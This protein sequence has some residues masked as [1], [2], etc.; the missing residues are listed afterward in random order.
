MSPPIRRKYRASVAFATGCRRIN[1]I[2]RG[3]RKIRVPIAMWPCKVEEKMT[4]KEVDGKTIQE[5]E[6]KIIAKDGTITRV[7]GTFQGYETSEEESVER[8][9]KRDLYEFVNHP[10]LQQRSHRNEFAPDYDEERAMEPRPEPRREATPTLRLRS[11]GVRR[12]RERVV[13]SEE[14]PNREGNRRG[15]NA[16]GIRPSDEAREGNP[17]AGDTFAYHPQGGYIPQAFTNNSI[18]S[19]NGPMHPIV[20]P[21]SNYPFYTQPMYAPPNMPVYP[22]PAG[23]FAD[24]ASF[25]TPFVRWIEDYPLPDELKMPSHIGSYDGKGDPD[26][27]LHLF[28]GVI[29]MQKWL[30]PAK[31]RS[32]FSRKKKFTKTHLAVYNI[33]QREGESTRAFI[34]RYT[35]DTLQI[36][37]SHEEQ[38]ISGFI[39]GLRTRSLVEHLSTDLPSTYKDLMEKAYTWVEAR[40]VVT[41]GVLNN[42]RDDSE[43]SKK[44]SWG[45]NIGQK[46]RGRFS[47]YKGQNHKLLFNLVKSPKEILT[48]EKVAKTFKQPLG[49]QRSQLSKMTRQILHFHEDYG[50]ETNQLSGLRREKKEEKK[51]TLD[52]FSVLM[53]SRKNHNVKKRP[54]NHS[55]IGEITFLPLLNVGSADPVIIKVCISRRQVNRVYLDGGSSCEVIYEHCFLKL[56]PLIRSLRVDSNTLL[57]SFSGEQSWP[58]GEIPLEIKIG[59]GSFAITK[60]L[61]FIIVKSDSPH[62]LLLGITVMQQMGIVVSTVHEAIKFHTP[63]GIGTIFLEYNSQKPKEEEGGSTNKHQGNEESVLSCIDTEER[64]VINDK[65]PEQ[66][67]TIGRHLPTRIKIRLRDLLKKYID[68]FTWTSAHIIGVPRVLMIRGEAFNTKHQINVFNHAEPIKQK[69]RSLALERNKVIHNQVEDL[70]EVGILREAKYQTWVSNPVVV[71]KDNGKWKLRVYFTNINKACIKEPHPL[72]AA[73]QKAEGL[74]KYRLKCFLEAYKGYHQIPIAEKDEEKTT[75]RTR[76]GVPLKE[77]SKDTSFHENFEKLYERKDGLMD[78]RSRRSLPKNERMLRVITNDGHTNKGGNSNNVPRNLRRNHERTE[79]KYP[80]LE[81]LILAL[82]YAARKLRRYFQA[83][84]IQVLSDKPIKQI[85]AKLEKS[86]RIAKWA[87]ELGEHKIEFK[88]RNLI[89]GKILADFLAETPLPESKEAKNKE[90]KRKELKPKNAWKHSLTEPQLRWLGA[91]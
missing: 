9:G 68:V 80:K 48:T 40:E 17:P 84:P 44:L 11:L 33:K 28:K 89:K 49:Y 12:Q 31:F 87:I 45:N 86:G 52:K 38:R 88:G 22:Y 85:L 78:E 36:L 61:T 46:D 14:A 3:N 62:N 8:P 90:I 55:E 63:R 83:H 76:E 26:N 72:P 81:K 91:D 7:P 34:T 82:V 59:D 41:N 42:R 69:K 15:M 25:V 56:I 51:P 65:Y 35:N 23:P 10:Q 74:H 21:S 47:P 75:F 6:T 5:F 77:C 73:E 16:E 67:I 4:L 50:T 43:R 13:G 57:V 20:A 24:S 18:P 29:R 66:M 79:L 64:V 71:K 39:H 54:A 32:H 53:I 58:L 2:R 60:T 70:T 30:M 1:K 19:Y 27:F 37:G